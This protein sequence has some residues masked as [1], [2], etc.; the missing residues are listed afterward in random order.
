MRNGTLFASTREGAVGRW[1]MRWLDA[2]QYLRNGIFISHKREDLVRAVAVGQ[3]IMSKAKVPCYVDQLD[4]N[5][6]GDS[7]EL[8]TYIQEVIHQ[9]RSLLAVVS[10]YTQES[11]WVPLEIGVALENQNHIGTFNTDGTE[12][13][14]YLWAWPTMTTGQE[15]VEWANATKRNRDAD[16][17]HRAWRGRD[18]RRVVD[19]AALY[20]S[21]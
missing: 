20:R 19:R 15:A 9:C 21:L 6:G 11:W 13:P 12:L 18:P 8:V 5:V 17:L 4:P 14:S 3:E 16:Q 7:A 1:E 2:R 10:Q